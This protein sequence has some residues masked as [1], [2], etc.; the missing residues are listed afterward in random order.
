MRPG[1]YSLTLQNFRSYESF[2]IEPMGENIILL[3]E[4][5]AGKT[6][7][8]E[9]LS[10][11]AP[12]RGLRRAKLA[13]MLCQRSQ[14][15]TW[16]LDLVLHNGHNLINLST[17]GV[18]S[19]HK[20]RRTCNSF[21]KSE[22]TL[23]ALAKYT[24]LAWITPQMDRLF[25]EGSSTRRRFIDQLGT[26]LFAGYADMLTQYD[27]L[28]AEWSNVRSN[29]YEP[30]WL[31]ALE[32]QIAALGL[33]LTAKRLE[34][35]FLLNDKMRQR[36][37]NFPKAQ[38]LI[39][40][41]VERLIASYP[42]DQGEALYLQALA[43]ISPN[44]VEVSTP[45]IGPHKSGVLFHHQDKNI[46]ANLCS[47]GEQ[48]SLLLAIVLAFA[49]L[50]KEYGAGVPVLLLDEAV[51]H[52]DTARRMHLFEEI[53]DINVQTWMTGTEMS[54]FKDAKSIARFF[55]VLPGKAEE[56]EVKRGFL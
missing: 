13:D 21:G 56:V 45:P 7:L 48:K 12:G 44:L 52:L 34:L 42:K 46:P 31:K 36:A 29:N 23:N 37:S 14:G 11:F 19:P 18:I 30:Q 50:M 15:S 4:N 22:K 40:G 24:S 47:T 32:I 10:L 25:F 9:A 27:N 17:S 3:G 51:A 26:A 38:V 35:S 6:N 28:V 8:L 41:D 1:V 53:R 54:S 33:N 2:T 39:Q 43:Q 5:G 55:H 16:Q 20:E 49:E